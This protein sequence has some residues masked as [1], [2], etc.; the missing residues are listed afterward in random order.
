M[1][2]LHDTELLDLWERGARRHPLDRALLALT[3]ALP[4]I[5]SDTLADWSIGRRNRELARLRCHCFGPR[6]RGWLA[7][8]KC[9]EKLEFEMD[10]QLLA[11]EESDPSHGPRETISIHDRTFRL[12]TSRDLAQAAQA[13]DPAA[14]AARLATNCQVAGVAPAK[15]EEAELA[16]IGE[17]LAL[18]D[19]LAET[20][21]TFR[22]PDCGNKWQETLDLA[23]FFWTELEARARHLLVEI[24]T[25]ASAYGWS[26]GDILALSP[27]RRATYLEMARG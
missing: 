25:L 3:A 16:A 24:H 22:C 4:E 21:I 2:A 5:P 7:C 26:E 1:R 23:L 13:L 12:P 9:G 19:P 17:A 10:G 27:E 14:G 8:I 11:G 15:W 6:L 18:A 20:R